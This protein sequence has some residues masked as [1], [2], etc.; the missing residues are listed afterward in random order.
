MIE[1]FLSDAAAVQRM[2][3]SPIGSQLDS[4]AKRLTQLGWRVNSAPRLELFI[5][6]RSR[7][8]ELRR[9]TCGQIRGSQRDSDQNAER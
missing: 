1:Q 3:A 2:R 8:I 5:S 6:E 7:R 4:F 9:P